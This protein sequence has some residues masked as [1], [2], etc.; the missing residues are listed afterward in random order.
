MVFNKGRYF[1]FFLLI[2]LL[3]SCKSSDNSSMKLAYHDLTARYNRY[4][5]AELILQ[6]IKEDI[7]NKHKDNYDRLL[8]LQPIDALDS[9]EEYFPKLDAAIKKESENIQLHENSKWTDDAYFH[10][11]EAYYL[12]GDFEKA[13]KAFVNVTSRVETGIREKPK[14]TDKIRSKGKEDEYN[15][16]YDGSSAFLKHKPAR[17][18]AMLWISRAYARLGKY[19]DA[20]SV[21]AL[22]KGDKAFPE[23][24]K[25]ELFTTE[26]FIFILKGDYPRAGESLK[27]AIE[28]S[29]NKKLRARYLFI[30]A[31]LYEKTGNFDLAIQYY[32][33]VLEEHPEIEMEFNAKLKIARLSAR[34]RKVSNEY[35]ISLLNN[36]LKDERYEDFKGRIY[37]SLGEIYLKDGME[38]KAIENFRE[39]I[40]FSEG[41]ESIKSNAY[42]R[43]ANYYFTLGDYVTSKAYHDSTLL[44][45][46]KNLGLFDTLNTRRNILAE[47]T[48]RL[49]IIAHEDSMQAL[50]KMSPEELKKLKEKRSKQMEEALE[51]EPEEE[52]QPLINVTNTNSGSA[53]PF[54]NPSLK[55]RGYNEFRKIW[56]ERPH[57]PMWRVRTSS[58]G[59]NPLS[60][61]D[62]QEG[63]ES[64]AESSAAG[65]E[66]GFE[67]IPQSPEELQASTERIIDAYYEL[68]NIYKEELHDIKKARETYEALFNKYPQNKYRLEVAYRLYLLY[69]GVDQG[70]SDYYKNIVLSEYPDSVLAKIIKD[71]DYLRKQ[72][73]K[74]NEAVSYYARTFELFENGDYRGTL[75]RVREARSRFAGSS[76][77][78]KFDMLEAL[79]YGSLGIYDTMRSKLEQIVNKYPFDEVKTRAIAILNSM[80][81]LSHTG[82]SGDGGQSLF[83]YEPNSAHFLAILV[84]S[85]GDTAQLIKNNLANYNSEYHS[86]ENLKIS[87]MLLNNNA[88]I[89]LVKQ[90]PNAE[91]AQNFYNEIRYNEKIFDALPKE[92]YEVFSITPFNYGVFF[93]EKDVNAYMSFFTK[94]YLEQQ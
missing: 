85:V 64:N 34:L 90:F 48:E 6:E 1:L 69:Q 56:G 5:N 87:S 89:V 16:Y 59:I 81:G 86:L 38:E 21:L 35:V 78:S 7:N 2:I 53:W 13:I 22:A 68:A 72:E 41:D 47:I 93:R 3:A 28:L 4:F 11:G 92:K 32:K 60:N 44:F 9:P 67:D 80:E 45:L 20:Q 51:E 63:G 8:P 26:A 77:M 58:S 65:S 62:Q 84:Y 66:S 36:M 79:S 23:P 27:R 43:L 50:A 91:K 83:K 42:L 75:D 71:P 14:K 19:A 33:Q 46:D 24:L 15:P 18:E 57:I 73:N 30:L 70:K 31:Q 17:Y 88:Q 76:L 25:E 29:N 49:Q 40:R 37:Y 12:K 54:D 10:I 52:M 94:N 82:S 61:G 74:S 55:G 39:A